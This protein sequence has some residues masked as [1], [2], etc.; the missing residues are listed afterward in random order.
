ML[1]VLF[2]IL[3]PLLSMMANP[4]VPILTDLIQA[5]VVALMFLFRNAEGIP[6]DDDY[7][8]D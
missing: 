2:G 4:V 3:A 1:A 6:L 7:N 8:I 5:V